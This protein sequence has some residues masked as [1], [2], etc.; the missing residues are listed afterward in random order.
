MIVNVWG[1]EID[2]FVAVV[3]R[4]DSED[5]IAAYELNVSCPNISREWT[6]FGVNPELTR[7]LV[8][9]VREAT[10]R[11]LM[12]KLSP[13]AADIAAVGRAAED[14]GADS[15]S[16]VNTILGLERAPAA[17]AG[18]RSGRWRCAASGSSTR[19]SRFR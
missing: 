17:S 14:A 8:G 2:D 16:A 7:E 15:L 1:N 18:R 5:G 10:G 19:R 13:N 12:V 3:E 4:L 6:E 9:R 11:H